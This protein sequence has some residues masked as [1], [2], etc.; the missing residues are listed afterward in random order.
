MGHIYI[1]LTIILTVYG[2]LIV[3]WQVMEAGDLPASWDGKLAFLLRLLLNPWILSGFFAAF[4]AAMCWMAAM[5]KF[6][7]SYAYP[8]MGLVFALLL[9]FSAVLFHE[10]ITWPK[11]VGTALIVIGVVVVSQ[12]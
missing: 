5:T 10:P 8:Y 12:G 1:L 3:K 4:L 2:Q 11:L 9:L 6:Q 7:L